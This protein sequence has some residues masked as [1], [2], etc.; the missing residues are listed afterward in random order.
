[1]TPDP[2]IDSLRTA[3]AAERQRSLELQVQLERAQAGFEEFISSSAHDLREPLRDVAAFSQLLAEANAGRLACGSEEGAFLERIRKG[4]ER[5]QSLLA[6]VVDYWSLGE[7]GEQPRATNL[8]AVFDQA[9]LRAGQP[10]AIVTHDPLPNLCGDFGILTKV[11]HHLIRNAIEYSGRPDPRI[12]ISAE[13]RDL[14]WVISVR[15]NGPGIEARFYE[16]IFGPFQRL[17]GREFPGN[18]LGLAFCR[19]AIEGQGGRMWVE[20]TLGAGATFFFTF[21][22]SQPE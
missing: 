22:A 16:R 5:M 18:G 15:D 8:E 7:C 4:A 20:S 9:L 1:M 21:P 14:E 13:H 6:D 11:L 19:K 2:E 12:H 3:L 10:D 17:H